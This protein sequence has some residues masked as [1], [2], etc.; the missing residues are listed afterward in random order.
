MVD[1]W[2]TDCCTVWFSSDRGD[3]METHKTLTS[4]VL[5]VL[6]CGLAAIP[7][8]AGGRIN[9][10]AS[11]LGTVGSCDDAL[12]AGTPWVII[13]SDNLQV[14]TGFTTCSPF[15]GTI[16]TKWDLFDVTPLAGDDLTLAVKDPSASWG[17]FDEGATADSGDTTCGDPL[18]G[19]TFGSCVDSATRT[20]FKDTISPGGLDIIFY[21]D[22]GALQYLSE[23]NP[24]TGVETL[25][26]GEFPTSV[27]EPSSVWLFMTTAAVSA[28]AISK[29]RRTTTGR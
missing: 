14:G 7:A 25:L 22:P 13:Q 26:A 8:H 21:T 6:V 10:G 15:N 12:T 20:V 4:L 9:Q 19:V 29:R 23:T 24:K 17:I 2:N 27:P 16:T 1:D 18:G 11:G 3:H 28:A 5:C